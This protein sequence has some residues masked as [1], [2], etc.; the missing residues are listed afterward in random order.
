MIDPLLRLVATRRTGRLAAILS[1]LLL[2]GSLGFRP[3]VLHPV[4]RDIT[5]P[6]GT[7]LTTTTTS[8]AGPLTASSTSKVGIASTPDGGGYW[9]VQP[10]GGV[11]SYGDAI[12]HG[13]MGGQTLNAPMVGIARTAS[14]NGYW[15]VGA[16]G[17]VFNFGDATLPLNCSQAGHTLN[18][19]V[20]GVTAMP[21]YGNEQGLWMVGGDG[22]VFNCG[23]GQFYG[24]AAGQMPSSVVGIAATSDGG[25]YW[26]ADAT[27]HIKPFGD[28]WNCGCS[29]SSQA[30]I[31]GIVAMPLN[32]GFWLVASD[33]GIF[34]VQNGANGFYG[35]IG[36][37]GYSGVTA[38]A[39]S[40]DERGYWLVFGGGTVVPFGDA[41]VMQ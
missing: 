41:G 34:S 18:A 11:F 7:V 24:S 32:A 36:G 30:P 3:L 4:L 20:V 1:A 33:G 25:G 12:F 31:V 9:L 2:L 40:F 15:E 6:D 35:A 16:D 10:D 13:G 29:V 8:S 27:G 5:L 37:Q 22:G 26:V 14:G 19:P 39:A 17:G 38:M 23:T 28:A 21:T